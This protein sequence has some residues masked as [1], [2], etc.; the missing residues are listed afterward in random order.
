M[1]ED[2]VE[3][4]TSGLGR[5]A[6]GVAVLDR[7][8][9]WRTVEVD[10]S[11]PHNLGLRVGGPSP[12]PAVIQHGEG[13][14]VPSPPLEFHCHGLRSL[15]FS[16]TGLFDLADAER[17]AERERV[18]C[19]PTIFLTRSQLPCFVALT[20]EF[21]LRRQKG[22]HRRIVGMGVEGP[23]LQSR[24]GTPAGTMWSPSRRDWQQL[25][26][27]G[28]SGLKYVVLAPSVQADDNLPLEWIISLLLEAGISPAIG[29][30]DRRHLQRTLC[31]IRSILRAAQRYGRRGRYSVL[32][33]HLFNDTPLVFKHAWRTP[34]EQRRRHRQLEELDLEGWSV[35][36]LEKHVG[37][38]AGLLMRAA[39]YGDLTL[40]LNFDGEHVDAAVCRRVVELV[41]S[42]AIIAM[43]DRV[44]DNRLAD[45]GLHHVAGSTLWYESTGA[46]AAGS[47]PIDQHQINMRTWG[48]TESEIWNL[49]AWVALSALDITDKS[50]GYEWTYVDGV[51]RSGLLTCP[52]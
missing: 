43:T 50:V 52:H 31:G 13:Y 15:D 24:G 14:F 40:C 33:D 32:T 44:D 47:Q 34:A 22:L 20:R 19:V 28:D 48:L 3:L 42:D 41:G 17:E 29:H 27:C 5:E 12:R 10:A 30:F 11:R 9:G 38:V 1:W 18:L 36:S 6:N 51:G 2:Y 46:V 26:Q 45:Q 16:G 21:A 4:A 25:A 8:W 49:S 23:F 39:A 37:E 7:R 35:D